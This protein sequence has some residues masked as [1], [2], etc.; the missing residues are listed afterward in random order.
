MKK[1]FFLSL[2]CIFAAVNVLAEEDSNCQWYKEYKIIGKDQATG[3]P[4]S[5][6]VDDTIL[7]SSN[8]I[9][10]DSSYYVAGYEPGWF[11][12]DTQNGSWVTY[13][14]KYNTDLI[15]PA[16]K[17]RQT[18]VGCTKSAPRFEPHD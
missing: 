8:C 2:F 4:V 6:P 18:F 14:Q 5:V 1:A 12:T 13:A 17:Q 15:N 7:F 3:L 11:C 16:T 10:I 9:V